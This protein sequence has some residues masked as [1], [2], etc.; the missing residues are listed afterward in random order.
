VVGGPARPSPPFARPEIESVD[1]AALVFE[2]AVWGTEPG[3]L[4][5]Q[6]PPPPA[7][8]DDGR[9]LLVKLSALGRRPADARGAPHG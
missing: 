3:D 2:L 6:D 5:F 7:A 4:A 9:S 8:L 1:L